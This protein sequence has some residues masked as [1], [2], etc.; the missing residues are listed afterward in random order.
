MNL[1]PLHMYIQLNLWQ[2]ITNLPLFLVCFWSFYLHILAIRQAFH[3]TMSRIARASQTQNK[4]SG[5]TP[6]ASR[7]V[8]FSPIV[9]LRQATVPMEKDRNLL[10]ETFRFYFP[11]R[12]Y[13]QSS[14]CSYWT[15][16]Y[17]CETTRE[18]HGYQPVFS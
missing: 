4:S 3:K 14:S 13:S 16:P 8:G 7:V 12:T 2:E 6:E 17:F 10:R 1:D 9:I 11:S 15:V 18:I 5:V